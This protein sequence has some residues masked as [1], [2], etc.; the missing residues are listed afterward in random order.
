MTELFIALAG[1]LVGGA[2]ST[3]SN[4]SLERRRE[5]RQ[6]AREEA[7]EDREVLRAARLIRQELGEALW[8]IK[9][10]VDRYRW[11]PHPSRR[12]P[13]RRWHEFGPTL[14]GAEEIDQFEW[15]QVTFAYEDLQDFEADLDAEYRSVAALPPFSVDTDRELRLLRTSVLEGHEV[16]SRL[17]GTESKSGFDDV[18]AMFHAAEEA[19]RKLMPG[20]GLVI[21]DPP[22]RRSK[23]ELLQPSRLKG[24]ALI[25]APGWREFDADLPAGTTLTTVVAEIPESRACVLSPQGDRSSEA[26]LTQRFVPEEIRAEAA[27]ENFAFIVSDEHRRELFRELPP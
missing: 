26:E 16:V 11:W 7:R 24:V 17:C 8:L 2:I 23:L 13:A 9:R 3:V 6:V 1:V 22:R 21:G 15:L 18:A 19:A 4:L 14:A 20:K 5:R 12:F 10:A 25:N 27:Y